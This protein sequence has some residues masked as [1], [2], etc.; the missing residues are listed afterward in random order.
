MI[1][2]VEFVVLLLWGKVVEAAAWP[3]DVD[4]NFQVR[5]YHVNDIHVRLDEINAEGNDCNET[6]TCYGGSSRIKRYLHEHRKSDRPSM[7]LSAGDESTGTLF[8]RNIPSFLYFS[9][10]IRISSRG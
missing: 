3:T 4:G 1:L 5:V 2:L 9:H 6:E 10:P 7:L 8:V